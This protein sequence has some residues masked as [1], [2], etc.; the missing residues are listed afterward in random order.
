MTSYDEEFTPEIDPPLFEPPPPAT[1]LGRIF[2]HRARQRTVVQA[3]L[4]PV[5]GRTRGAPPDAVPAPVVP[6]GVREA[7][8]AAAPDGP[9]EEIV[10]PPV[11][12]PPVVEPPVTAAV[13]DADG[14]RHSEPGA[15]APAIVA[16]RYCPGCDERVPV[17]ADGLHCHLGHRLSP[18]HGRSRRGRLRRGRR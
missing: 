2:A 1:L 17:A 14:P 15:A 4:V 8:P 11:V 9:D 13:P 5:A 6:E 16:T 7:T 10:G 12:G 18:A 3:P